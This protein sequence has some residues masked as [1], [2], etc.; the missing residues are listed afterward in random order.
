MIR[1]LFAGLAALCLATPIH[2][3]DPVVMRVSHQLPPGH[4]IAGVIEGFASDVA[5][6]TDGAVE[7]QVFPANQAF[8]P[9]ENFPAVA[10]GNI[11]AALSVNFQWGSTIPT[12]NVTLMPFAFTDLA[13]LQDFSA[14]PVAAFLEEELAA[15]GVTNLAWLFTTRMSIFTSGEKPLVVPEDFQGVKIRGLNRLVDSGLE[16]LGAAP[17]AMSGSEVYQALQTGVIDAGLTDVA[18]AVSRKYFE[19]QDYGTITPLF[20]VFFHLYVNPDW[21]DDLD[22]AH[23]EAIQAAAWAAEAAALEATEAAAAEAPGFLEE[24]GMTLHTHSA[25]EQAVFAGIM[26][27]AFEAAFREAVG[28]GAERILEL[29]GQ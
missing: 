2:A 6:R 28:E 15:K 26:R 17:V 4:H 9:A 3:A 12:M 19:V 20:S 5:E 14:S 21:W 8:Q 7:V 22:P 10:R 27:P 23:Q 24:A 1:Y 16:S 18:A 29:I 13:L 25:E 11:E